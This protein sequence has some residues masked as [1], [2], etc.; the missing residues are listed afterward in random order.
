ML[1]LHSTR[2]VL[3]RTVLAMLLAGVTL[4][5]P[6]LRA[7]DTDEKD[8]AAVRDYR[9]AYGLQKKKLFTQ[10][11]TRWQN[12]IKA[13]VDHRL[14]PNAN[15]HLGVSQFQAGKLPEAATAFRTVLQKYAK[16]P[17]RDGAQFNLSLVLFRTAEASQKPEDFKVAATEFANVAKTYGQSQYVPSALYY[18]AES[19]YSSGDKAAAVPVY[20]SVVQKFGDS[21]LLPGVFY[22]LG[23]CLQDLEKPAEA[24]GA[25]AEYLKRFPAGPQA[26]ECRLRLGVTLF[27]QKKYPEAQKEFATAAAIPE[28]TFADYAVLQHAQCLFQ[29]DKLKEAA[30]IYETLPQ[31]FAESQ[32]VPAARLAAG[33]C[34][35]REN[36][37]NKAAAALQPVSAVKT[38]AEAPEASYWLG[39]SLI[40]QKKPQDAINLLTQ[41][42]KDYAASTFL[43]QISLAQIDAAFEIPDQRAATAAQYAAFAAK[44]TDHELAAGAQYR[45]CFAAHNVK[46]YPAAAAHG[47]KY[48]AN[49]AW[50]KHT[51]RPDVMFLTGESY[52]LTETPDFAKA[53]ASYRRLIAEHAE[54]SYVPQARL[55]TGYCL[56]RG[57]KF[58]DV[59]AWLNQ[60]VAALTEPGQKAEA[61]LLIGRSHSDQ[62]RHA[63][64]TKAFQTSVQSNPKWTRS[65]EVV[66]AL[67][68]SHLAQEQVAPAKTELQK[69]VSQFPESALKARGH[70]HLGEIATAEK[71]YDPAIASYRE[72][73][74][75][76]P[77]ES[78]GA[79]AQ[80]G[81][82]SAAFEK[83]DYAV[84]VA[85]CS[86]L[87]TKYPQAETAPG[88]L[89]LRGLSY[90]RMDKFPEAAKD[91]SE[92][93]AKNAEGPNVPDALFALALSQIGAKQ[94]DAGVTTLN[95]LIGKHAD[96]AQVDQALYEL[97]F[98]YQATDKSEESTAAF[99]RLANE[100][101]DSPLAPE[102]W[103]RVGEFHESKDDPV[104]AEA[105]FMAGLKIAKEPGLGERLSYKLGWS[106]YEQE[107]W[108]EA[109][110]TLQQHVTKF[111]EGTLIADASFLAGECAYKAGDF[112]ASLPHY[113][114]V[115]GLK[116][117]KYVARALY[118]SGDCA[119]ALKNWPASRTFYDTLVKGHPKFEQIDEARYGHGWA[120]QNENQLDQAIAVYEAI[121]KG[122]NTE[123]AA[124]ACFM[125]GEC[126]F[127]QKKYDEAVIHF[128][129]VTEGYSFPEW[130]A[131]S[132]FELGRCFIE[133]KEPERARETFEQFMKDYPEHARAKDA[134]ALLTSLK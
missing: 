9:V 7:Q 120:L 100:K 57:A 71:Q 108:K 38:L 85:E 125:M 46:D 31:K 1:R 37:F 95:T 15:Y 68:L 43:P 121:P 117:E 61:W 106:Q 36:D 70:F 124:K 97:A 99:T 75:L 53:E 48:L 51:A 30:A 82:T 66:Y 16:F 109:T 3:S 80:Y 79:A 113:Q 118:R 84:A 105:A 5:G 8:A 11:A 111:P 58:D 87:L 52:L 39:R 41:A 88:A 27:D 10:A 35:Y 73:L 92:Y 112:Q 116:S 22:A 89:Y 54:S 45:A 91:L 63:E 107:K 128:I 55:R 102:A 19:L 132:S 40:N 32:Y 50:A 110:A 17:S 90:Q 123:T 18:Q 59:V 69:L 77:D 23:T 96:Y 20:Q 103:F 94:H 122:R 12:F 131:L 129:E 42:A 65:D 13:H 81:I 86:A 29:Q 4:T 47:E 74:K 28:F 119:A 67:A 34:W 133:L 24:S 127:G 72:A 78:L 114:K 115:I 21:P 104:K 62:K 56:Y 14:Q 98:A 60:S 83:P 49:G 134:T 33:K 76:N 26:A 44:F 126:R 2:C 6:T 93:V 64:A 101:A 130:S 25:Y